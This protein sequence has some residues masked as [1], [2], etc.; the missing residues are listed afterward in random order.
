M[1]GAEPP[2]APRLTRD[3]LGEIAN[4]VCG[5][6]VPSLGGPEDVF[7]LDAPEVGPVT[8]SPVRSNPPAARVVIGA[9]E[10]QAKLAL[11]ITGAVPEM[12]GGS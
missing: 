1:L 4:V 8:E 3:A 2:V 12:E 9:G 10:G 11:H 6:L 5:N 7:H